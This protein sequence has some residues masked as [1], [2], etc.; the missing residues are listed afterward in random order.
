MGRS[1][2]SGKDPRDPVGEVIRSGLEVAKLT[3]GLSL[4]IGSSKGGVPLHGRVCQTLIEVRTSVA[5]CGHA[6]VQ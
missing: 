4:E 2:H 3:G 5:R 1:Q 6:L